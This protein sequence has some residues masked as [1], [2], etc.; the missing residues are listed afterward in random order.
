[1]VQNF[2]ELA[3]W[4]K[5]H[6]LVLDIYRATKSL[7][8]SE[9]FGLILSLRRSALHIAS[10]IAEGAGRSS[11][12]EFAGEL[13]KARATAYELEYLLLVS[14]DLSFLEN[15]TYDE[16]ANDLIETRKMISGLMKRLT[17]GS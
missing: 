13:G 9:N 8:Q 15:G 5:A 17:S 3:V 6:G 2:T 11:D 16:L 1:V 10:R 4:Q 7:P 14:R 12:M